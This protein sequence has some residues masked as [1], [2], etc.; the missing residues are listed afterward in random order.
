[1]R[2]TTQANNVDSDSDLYSDTGT[3][4]ADISTMD[5]EK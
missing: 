3:I 4:L 5:E 1:M 2:G